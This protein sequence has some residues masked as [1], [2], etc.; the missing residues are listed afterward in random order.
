MPASGPPP[1]NARELAPKPPRVYELTGWKRK[2]NADRVATIGA[3]GRKA[4]RDP[5]LARLAV[6]IFKAAGVPS[7][8]FRGQARALHEFLRDN[9]Y[10]V[11][12]IDERLQDP[13]YTLDLQEDGT[14]GQHAA[15]DCDDFCIALIA[16]CTAVHLPV[17][18]VTSGKLR[19]KTVRYVEGVGR[20]PPARWSHIYCAVS[21]GPFRTAYDPARWAFADPTVPTAPFGWDVVG[22]RLAPGTGRAAGELDGIGGD[23][24]EIA[25]MSFRTGAQ[26]VAVGVL[27]S[28]ALRWLERVGW[29]PRVV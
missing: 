25:G 21:D 20:S 28:I 8:D 9:V 5:R 18:A 16:L 10:F 22:A 14:V 23:D 12:E 13:A 4:G 29:L 7:R 17:R 26:L 19:G 24:D 2:K 27:T 11:H 6:Q 3:I 1:P 15:G